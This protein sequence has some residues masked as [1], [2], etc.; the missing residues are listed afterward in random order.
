[1]TITDNQAR[2]AY[3]S[4]TA[5]GL[6]PKGLTTLQGFSVAGT[7][8]RFY[9]ANATIDGEEIV[10]SSPAVQAPVA[11]RYA[12]YTDPRWANLFNDADMGA[13]PFR[14]DAW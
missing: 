14:T 12:W 5:V 8:R 10:V 1:M 9:W 11:V 13:A 4:G 7:D 3:R 2:I 6:H